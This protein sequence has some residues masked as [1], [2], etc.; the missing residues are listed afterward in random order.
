MDQSLLDV[1]VDDS[2]PAP[3][4]LLGNSARAELIRDWMGMIEENEREVIKLRY[5][6]VDD[7]PRTL[8][9]IGNIFGVTRE[10]VRQIE[11]KALGKLRGIIE[12]EDMTFSDVV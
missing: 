6:F 4:E 8:E 3:N 1:L 9:A 2:F 10:R 11:M 5:G 7:A 12:E